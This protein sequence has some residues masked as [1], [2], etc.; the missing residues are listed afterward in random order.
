M[1]QIPVSTGDAVLVTPGV[2]HGIVNLGPQTLVFLII[3]GKPY[4]EYVEQR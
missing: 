1:E 4:R 3:F 2:D